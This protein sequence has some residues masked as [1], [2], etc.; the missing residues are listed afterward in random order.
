MRNILGML[1]FLL[2]VADSPLEKK[3]LKYLECHT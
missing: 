1:A 3:R 2:I